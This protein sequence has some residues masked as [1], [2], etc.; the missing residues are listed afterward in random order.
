MGGEDGRWHDEGANDAAPSLRS[1]RTKPCGFG[2]A[3]F[4]AT[5]TLKKEEKTMAEQSK[6]KDVVGNLGVSQYENRIKKLKSEGKDTKSI[7]RSIEKTLSSFSYGGDSSFVIFGEPQSGK[8]EMMIALNAKLLDNGCDMI[9]NL[10]NDS[11]DLLQQNLSRFRQAGLSPAPKQFSELPSDPSIVS[12]KQLILFSK[13]NARDLEKLIESL[14][15][16]KK[17]VIIDDE[18]DY[19]SPNAKINSGERTKINKLIQT[20]LEHRGKYIGVTATPAR[21]DLNNTFENNSELWV[22]FDP[23]SSYVGQ[24]FFF[25]DNRKVE[26]RLHT[27]DRSHG[28]DRR[29]LK[30]AIFHF[31]CGV[32]EQHQKGRCENFTMIIH[33]SGKTDE[34][35]E[36]YKVV[37]DSINVLSNADSKNFN[38]NVNLLIK[39]AR[40]YNSEDPESICEF[41]LRNINRNQIIEINS[42]RRNS[43]IADI[44]TPKVLFSFFFWRWR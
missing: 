13:K 39:I 22:D 31:L 1:P 41:I 15:F 17:L 38:T 24:N 11:V 34:H 44:L 43:N 23:H 5:P 3:I 30:N 27:F 19:A 10:L 29:E 37:Q 36:D 6:W 42:K 9:I 18:A 40:E 7:E 26:Y 21:L 4:S 28:D 25:P 33:T 8:T 12:E 20:L 35:A 16:V 32:A 14:R 2:P